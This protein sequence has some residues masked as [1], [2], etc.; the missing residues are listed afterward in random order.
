MICPK[1]NGEPRQV[2]CTAKAEYVLMRWECSKCRYRYT[3]REIVVSVTK[4]CCECEF[5]SLD[6]SFCTKRGEN[7]HFCH[8]ICTE[9]VKKRINPAMDFA[10]YSLLTDALN[11]A[12]TRH[13]EFPESTIGGGMIIAEEYAEL[14]DAVK[15]FFQGINDRDTRDNLIEEATHV[16]ATAIRFIEGMIKK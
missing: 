4:R 9:Y 5:F 10:V 13:P 3:T 11:D 8:E 2:G 6:S 16:A 7:V 12:K 1:C 14:T 15:K